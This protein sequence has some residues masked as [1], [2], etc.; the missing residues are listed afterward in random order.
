MKRTWG[1][2]TRNAAVL[3]LLI[4]ALYVIVYPGN[5]YAQDATPSAAPQNTASESGQVMGEATLGLA[6]LIH[7][8]A[9]DIPDGSIVS[10]SNKGPNLSTMPYDPQVL[11]VVSRTAAIILNSGAGSD[12]VPVIDNGQVYVRVAN[13]NG[14]IKKGDLLTTSTIPGVAVKADKDGYVLGSALEDYPENNPQTVG[15]IAMELNLHYFNSKPTM[16]GTLT[17]ILK[18]AV[19]PTKD[20]PTALFK[21]IVAATVAIVSFVLTF[22]TFG[23]T[24][25]KGVEALGRNPSASGLIHLGIILNISISIAITLVGLIVAFLILRL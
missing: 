7:V 5:S 6:K 25:S 22:M 13:K 2:L 15:E 23:R 9:K 18:L 11:G 20:S 14:A 12:A 10:S 16:L 17:D 4:L 8:N 19:L 1:F 21:Y 3:T 24:A